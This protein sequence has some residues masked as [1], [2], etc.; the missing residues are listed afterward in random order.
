[1]I[2]QCILQF[3]ECHIRYNKTLFCQQEELQKSHK[4]DNLMEKKS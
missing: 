1:M 2:K 3:V 4:N